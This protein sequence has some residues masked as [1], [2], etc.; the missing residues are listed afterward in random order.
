MS[1]TSRI[2]ELLTKLSTILQKDFYKRRK[3]ALDL[4]AKKLAELN[5]ICN[6]IFHKYNKGEDIWNLTCK[7]N[8]EWARAD[9]YA[10]L[11]TYL[12]DLVYDYESSIAYHQYRKICQEA[13]V[14]CLK[15]IKEAKTQ[16]VW[17]A[18][19]PNSLAKLYEELKDLH[20]DDTT[21]RYY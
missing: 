3:T 14:I 18:E 13:I 6:V 9:F 19:I 16:P 17:I 1:D 8:T 5:K 4:Y 20:E 7:Y 15:V 12:G 2:L 10:N 21:I 11:K